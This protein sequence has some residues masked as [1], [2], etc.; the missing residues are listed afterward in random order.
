VA[1]TLAHGLASAGYTSGLLAL[2]EGP[3]LEEAG[4]PPR[5]T[6]GA[7]RERHRAR[8]STPRRAG[9]TPRG[10]VGNPSVGVTEK[11]LHAVGRIL[12]DGRWSSWNG[13]MAVP[14][15]N[16]EAGQLLLHRCLPARASRAARRASRRG[17]GVRD[18]SVIKRT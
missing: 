9:A 8:S 10:S 14:A 2:R 18:S 17:V 13:H 15:S 16:R 11:P 7:A 6:G 3:L 12:R 4:P 1:V 5:A